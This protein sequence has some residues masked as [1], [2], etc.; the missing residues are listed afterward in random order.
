MPEFSPQSIRYRS[1]DDVL[2]SASGRYFG[3]GHRQVYH[4][5]R[6]LEMKA[7]EPGL[8]IVAGKA[9]VAYPAGWSVK[10]PGTEL[11]PHLSSID[12]LV[13]ALGLAEC[14]V[15]CPRG[16]DSGQRR[17]M[18]VRSV[19][20]RAGSVPVT[21]LSDVPVQ[22][23]VSHAEPHPLSLC[24]S[25]S[26]VDCRVGAIKVNCGI[27]HELGYP[28]YLAP[29]TAGAGELLGRLDGRY[30]GDGY[31]L[32]EREISDLRVDPG[33]GRVE[34][35]VRVAERYGNDGAG[36]DAAYRPALSP[37][38][39][40][41]IAAQLAQVLIYTV[42]GLHR[43]GTSTLWMRHFSM[44][45]KTP[46]QPITNPFI[47]SLSIVRSRLA[48]LGGMTWRT[49][50]LSADMLGISGM[51]SVTHSLPPASGFAPARS[52]PGETG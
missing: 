45:V 42:D 43:E 14:C 50:D 15:A 37:V 41:V 29:F 13:L 12:A 33:G 17:R 6:S 22:A 20:M 2:G 9:K 38:D 5:L 18:W 19:R 27:E 1:I 49:V 16:L 40:I 36:I 3:D 7:C 28:R 4:H 46:Y 39:G 48:S 24:G 44:N 26:A 31:K 35:L 30:Y 21:E 11:R 52:A 10:I 23:R 47:T 32:T 34:A 51:F 25:T 8:G